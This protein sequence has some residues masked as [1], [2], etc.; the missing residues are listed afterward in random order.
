[1]M[2]ASGT[3]GLGKWRAGRLLCVWK[4][5]LNGRSYP[6]HVLEEIPPCV[7]QNWRWCCF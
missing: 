3:A 1:M 7:L 5:R 4:P 2:T 6:F